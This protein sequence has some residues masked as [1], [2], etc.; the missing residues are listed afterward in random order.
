MTLS[1]VLIANRGEIAIRIAKGAA[2]AGL[3][4]VGV[5]A[6]ADAAS[7]HIQ[8]TD[9]A[10]AL[11]AYPQPVDAYLDID[12]LVNLARETGCDC[13]HPGY[14][15]L[16]ESAALANACTAAG[17][18]F[19]GPDHEVLSLFGDKVAARQH[20][21]SL[22]IPVI[23]G[24]PVDNEAQARDFIAEYGLPVMIKAAAG[25]GGRGMRAVEHLEDLPDALRRCQSEAANAFG[26]G[27]LLVEKLL[28]DPQHI[29]VQI[30]GDQAGSI[31]HLYERD[32]SIQQRHQKVVEIAPAPQLT[33][34]LRQQLLDDAVKIARSCHYHNAGTVEFLVLP[35]TNAHF[36]I[37]CN[38]RIQVE[39][40][41]TEQI[42]GVDLVASQFHLAAGVTLAELGLLDLPAPT[43]FAVQ[44]RV[45]CQGS[46]TI[47]G[48]KEPAG[49]GIR[50]DGHGYAGYHPPADFDPL[51]AKLI[52]Y[53]PRGSYAQVLGQADRALQEFHIQGVATNIHQLIAIL[54]DPQVQAGTARTTLLETLN[55]P[56]LAAGKAAAMLQQQTRTLGAKASA[57]SPIPN[58]AGGSLGVPDGH[59][60]ISCPMAGAILEICAQVGEIVQAGQPLL[61][62]SAMKMETSITATTAGTLT[63][64][65]EYEI[66]SQLAAGEVVAVVQ[67]TAHAEAP[68]QVDPQ[69]SWLPTL[70]EV[71]TLR[72]LAKARLAPGA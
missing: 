14:G 18:T 59:I 31:T 53:Q 7:A 27:A 6:P 70:T 40:T 34:A 35:Q 47:V 22:G 23:P 62:I 51:L 58:Q 68:A 49:A 12:A 65:G 39:H 52:C 10:H 46:G 32:C 38:P 54:S 5:Y 64:L 4:S 15:F 44:C 29:E 2:S 3:H 57:A 17:L 55:T 21:Q 8:H 28:T 50:V 30:I 1:K 42:M 72:Q 36:F 45:V 67:P 66:G 11:P 48:Y 33:P 71:D 20:A 63:Q 56:S 60:G 69:Q 16:S 9:E 41:V 37:E 19:I 61:V 26:N 24:Q 25:G 43:G 13:I